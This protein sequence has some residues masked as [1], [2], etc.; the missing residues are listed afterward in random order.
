VLTIVRQGVAAAAGLTVVREEIVQKSVK[1]S[2]VEPGYAWLRISQFQ[3]PTVDDLADK[4]AALVRER[5][6]T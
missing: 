3:E 1:G 4:L 6:R 5:S 2:I